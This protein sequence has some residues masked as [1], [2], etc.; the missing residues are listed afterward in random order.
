L[1]ATVCEGAFRNISTINSVTIEEGIAWIHDQAFYG[2]SGMTDVTI[3]D[4]ITVIG[5]EAFSGCSGLSTVNFGSGV[6]TIGESAFAGCT[7]L[8]SVTFP[9]GLENIQEYAFRGCTG[10]ANPNIPDG[11]KRISYNAFYECP[12]VSIVSFPQS[13]AVP[14]KNG[15]GK[16]SNS[17]FGISLSVPGGLTFRTAQ[18]LK[19]Y[20]D[21]VR[22]SSADAGI[23][24]VETEDIL[25]VCASNQPMNITNGF[26]PYFMLLCT[27]ENDAT[28]TANESYAEL[29]K[30]SMKNTFGVGTFSSFTTKK[31]DGID[32]VYFKWSYQSFGQETYVTKI[33]GY[34]LAFVNTY[35][36]TADKQLINKI[37]NSIRFD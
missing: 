10:L 8:T 18:E 7:G 26:V 29:V 9:D 32:F 33:D 14:G 21:A 6:K 30:E 20:T 22:E 16:Y 31:I 5:N 37:V 24:Y 1:N 25:L 28:G 13:V 27:K 19:D 15:G 4:S 12:G 36:N 11:M 34:F 23:E 17:D 3:P 2:C 35:D